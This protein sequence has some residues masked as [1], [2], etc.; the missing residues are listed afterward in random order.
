MSPTHPRS[1]EAPLPGQDSAGRRSRLLLVFEDIVHRLSTRR[2]DLIAAH[3]WVAVIERWGISVLSLTSGVV[4]LVIFRRGIGHF[5]LFIG[6]LLL[7]WLVGVVFAEARQARAARGPKV[8]W[9]AVDYTVQTLFHGLL[10]FLLPVYYASTTLTS[11]DVLFLALLAAGA[12]LTAMDPW[13]QAVTRRAPRLEIVLFDLGL[14]AS[15]NL[16]FP[17]IGI[18]PAAGLL[19]SGAGSMLA[20]LPVFRRPTDASWLA[21]GLRAGVCAVL[22]LALLWPLRGWIPPVPLRVT[23]ATFARAVVELE[24]VQ[25]VKSVSAAVV[26]DWGSLT[27]FTAVSA[28]AGLREPIF[29]VWSKNGTVLERIPLSPVQGGV[30]GG[31]RTYSRKAVLG[32]DPAGSWSVDVV[33]AHQQLI[34]R[35][36]LT[37]TP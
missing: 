23:R 29:H 3:P 26:R 15:L 19:A 21:P 11:G 22:V 25:P 8:V 37:V 34:G 6:Y 24:P 7:L 16:A 5:P 17:L 14:F 18:E 2:A 12:L 32:E 36:R 10:L 28:P 1:S 13:Y 33:T 27:V 20:L 4:T 9:R 30:R 35:V 31:F